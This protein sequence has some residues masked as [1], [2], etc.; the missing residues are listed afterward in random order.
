MRL[1]RFGP[2]GDER[3]GMLDA[4][5]ARRDTSAFG[6]DWDEEF[7]GSDGLAR[8]TLWLEGHATA[9]PRVADEVRWASCVA[10]PS[11]IVC[12][13]LNYRD[14]ARE[15]G[16]AVPVEP[17]LFAKSTSS[18]VGPFDDLWLPPDSTKTDWEVE[19]AV[20]I[21]RRALLVSEADAMSFVAGYALH[22]DYSERAFQLEHHGQWFKG[23]SW[24]TFA[25]LGPWLATCDEIPDP[26]ALDLWLTV[27]GERMQQSSTA[28]MIFGVPFLVSYI[29]QFMTLLPGDVISTGTAAGVGLGFKPPRYLKPGDVI[30]LSIDGLGTSR[31]RAVAWEARPG[32]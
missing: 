24:D 1:I 15:T 28:Q 16:G 30:E 13:G 20:V 10:R 11:K 22:N 25:P 8:L 12:I 26:H 29:S 18:L 27:N 9:L 23:K 32:A 3:P 17:I 6:E 14:H 19:L 7:F 21:S 5:G 2:V 31:Q 4:D